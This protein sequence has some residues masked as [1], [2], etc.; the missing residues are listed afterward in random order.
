[1]DHGDVK[2]HILALCFFCARDADTAP[3][4]NNTYVYSFNLPHNPMSRNWL[5]PFHKWGKWGPERL[6]N[7]SKKVE[8][9]LIP[10]HLAP[11]ICSGSYPLSQWCY[12]AF[13]FS[14]TLLSFCLQSFLVSGSFPMSWLFASGGQNIGASASISVL[15]MNVQGWFPLRL[16]GLI[17]LQ[18][19]G[20]SG[21]FCSTTVIRKHRI[22]SARSSL[23]SNY[24]HIC[25]LLE[26]P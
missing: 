19:K 24:T 23:W 25:T 5:S 16:I 17:S 10:G 8:P 15:S 1:M 12:L 21:V 20:L 4:F 22:I 2:E 11:G 26:K 9:R 6:C 13:S 18:S 7:L 3:F 14:A